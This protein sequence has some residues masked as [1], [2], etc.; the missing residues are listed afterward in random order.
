[1]CVKGRARSTL[2]HTTPAAFVYYQRARQHMSVSLEF[3]I[4]P[5]LTT[6]ED[7][8]RLHYAY[9]YAK[10]SAAGMIS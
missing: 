10:F 9:V 7:S 3:P 8:P 2:V 4:Q 6:P 5:P 1:M